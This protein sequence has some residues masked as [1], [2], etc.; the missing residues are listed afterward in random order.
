[1]KSGHLLFMTNLYTMFENQARLFFKLLII[2]GF[3]YGSTS[4]ILLFEGGII[5]IKANYNL[6]LKFKVIYESMS[7]YGL[8]YLKVLS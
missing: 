7:N 4:I 5:V 8:V 3:I 2:N 6:T 1:M